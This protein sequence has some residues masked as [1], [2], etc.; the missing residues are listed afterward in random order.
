MTDS[1]KFALVIA[2]NAHDGNNGSAVRILMW[3]KALLIEDMLDP[4]QRK[5]GC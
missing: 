3:E 1:L 4:I 5:D 2:G